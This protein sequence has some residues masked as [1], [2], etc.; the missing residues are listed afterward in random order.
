[1]KVRMN[2]MNKECRK[3]KSESIIFRC[4]HGKGAISFC[5]SIYFHHSHKMST[6]GHRL[7]WRI[8]NNQ[9]ISHHT[10]SR[11]TSRVNI[12]S[13]TC[14]IL[15]GSFL[16]HWEAAVGDELA[17]FYRV[18]DQHGQRAEKKEARRHRNHVE[19]SHWLYRIEKWNIKK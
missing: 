18:A 14:N 12:C 7:L 13:F 4:P 3:V 17:E 1:M 6:H 16:N 5:A 9:L 15:W 11:G 8:T 10:N 19:D 2:R